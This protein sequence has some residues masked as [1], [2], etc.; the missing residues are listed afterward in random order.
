M[1]VSLAAAD[2]ALHVNVREKIHFDAALPFAL[3]S[4]AASAGNVERESSRLVSAL[5][6][7]RQ[8]GVEIANL[9]EYAGIGCRIG[10]RRA[11]DRRLIDANDF[12]DVLRSGNGFVRAGFFARPIQPLARAR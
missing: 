9:R 10:T 1:V 7:F 8:H 5:A 4:F 12:I 3:A 2:F 11:A 6:R